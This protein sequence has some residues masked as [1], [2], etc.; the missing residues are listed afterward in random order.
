MKLVEKYE[1]FVFDLDG[2]VYIEN[3]L[4]EGAKETING[5]SELGKNICFVSNKTTGTPR[6]Y[7][8]FLRKQGLNITEK[9]IITAGVVVK[10]YLSSIGFAGKFFAIGEKSFIDFLSDGKI[11]FSENVDEISLVLVTL[12][13]TLNYK[14]LEIAKEAIKKG[15][16]YFAVNI[17]AT[18]PVEKGEI[19]DA[20]AIISALEKATHKTPTKNFGKP[21]DYMFALIKEVVEI[22]P[23]S[24]LI[25]GDRL[26][27]DIK[28]GNDFGVD[29]ALVETGVPKITNGN[30]L[31]QPTYKLQSIKEILNR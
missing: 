3:N 10:N 18:C 20:G 7:Y 14:K 31:I 19:L 2:T 4:I 30:Y 22:N 12:D 26:E 1:T 21:S 27:T 8:D 15:A 28:M 24:S 9:Q 5:L 6:D 25:I 11:E 23:Q 13:R 17:D 16:D 29:T